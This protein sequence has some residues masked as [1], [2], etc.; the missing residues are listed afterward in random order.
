MRAE[1]LEKL[2]NRPVKDTY[3]RYVGFVVG[4]SVDTSGDLK[5]VGVDIGNGEFTEYPSIRLVSTADGFVVIPAWKVESEALG[6]KMDGL[7]RRAKALQELAREGEIP[8]PLFDETMSKYSQEA[9]QVQDSYKSLAEGMV[10]RVGELEE[11]KESLDRFLVDVKVQYRSGEIDEAAYKVASECCQAMQQRNAQ[12][13]EELSKMLRAATEPLGT[14]TTPAQQPSQ[15]QAQQSA[16]KIAQPPVQKV[17][18][19]TAE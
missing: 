17:A 12:E 19:A 11:Q 4:F 18:Q 10:V 5:S 9:G 14:Q 7:R 6:K 1:A 16:Q 15:Q 13:R 2:V 3:G 8:R